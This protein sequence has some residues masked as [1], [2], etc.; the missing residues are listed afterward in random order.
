MRFRAAVGRVGMYVAGFVAVANLSLIYLALP[1][2]DRAFH[3]GIAAQAW[4]VGIYPL[5]E[6]GFALAAGT[7][8]DLFGRRRVLA[9]S[10]VIFLAASLA[11]VFAPNPTFLIGARAIQG[12][13]SATLLALPIAILLQ[14]ITDPV[15]CANTI[16]QFTLVV[17]VAAG[18]A[19]LIAGFLVHWFGWSGI[20]SFSGILAA[21]VLVTLFAVDEDTRQPRHALDIAGQLLSV[22]ALL[23]L[24]YVIIQGGKVGIVPGTFISVLGVGFVAA[25]LFVLAERHAA[26]P[27]VQ[28][29]YFNRRTF[30][31]SLLTLGI[32]N[33]GWYGLMLVCTLCLQRT[34]L[35]GS[36]AVGLYLTPCNV[37][38][39]VANAYSARIARRAGM[40]AAIAI[41]FGVSL[42][43]MVWLFLP[44]AIFAP[45]TIC[46]AL[47]IAGTGWGLICTPATALGMESVGSA[48]EGFA[49]AMLVLSRSL[50]GVF[51][52][53]VLG[54]M[55]VSGT[56]EA[57]IAGFV[58]TL[59]TGGALVAALRKGHRVRAN[60]DL[61]VA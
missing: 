11:C 41:S 21:L 57:A 3:G 27:M 36:I 55:F 19:P 47:V 20:F 43:A 31:V 59:A 37:A 17:G 39:F 61:P 7:L 50:C 35:Q 56:A 16:K 10:T 22:I 49:S 52:V 40:G 54:S 60:A 33:F 8:G 26:H 51:G 1:G 9:I 46:A 6:G 58:V 2:I 12:I 45:W 24:S 4:I 42:A 29:E 23:A 15:A 5:M 14:N 30:G 25:A 34:M 44:G 38:F 13:G 53:A 32:V 28:L 48:D 18:A